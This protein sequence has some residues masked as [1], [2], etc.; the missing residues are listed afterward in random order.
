[1]ISNLIWDVDGTLFD[2]YPAFLSAFQ[3]ALRSFDAQAQDEEVDALARVSL[4]YCAAKLAERF[5]LDEDELIARFGK[6][7]SAIP[8][9]EQPPFAGAAEVCRH[10]VCAGGS[11]LIVTHRR[12]STTEELLK[13]YAL[14]NLFSDIAAGDEGYPK[15]PDPGAFLA[16]MERNHLDP[17][18]TAAVGDREIDFQAG[19]AAGLTTCWFG[20]PGD[21]LADLIFRDY[22]ELMDFILIF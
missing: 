7:Y 1:M 3:G 2:T 4:P 21:G 16:L 15:K 11:N 20:G 10:I 17:G 22:Q 13:A 19:K 6:L 14:E 9:A 18:V 12:R 5:S 8:K